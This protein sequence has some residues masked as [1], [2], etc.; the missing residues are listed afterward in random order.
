MQAG[1]TF[2]SFVLVPQ[3]PLSSATELYFYC[4][5]IVPLLRLS[6]LSV[7]VNGKGGLMRILWKSIPTFIHIV[8]LDASLCLVRKLI[9]PEKIVSGFM[10]LFARKIKLLFLKIC[11]D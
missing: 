1:D 4:C 6:Q 9:K 11:D 2:A 10:L 8:M 5:V 7:P 3:G